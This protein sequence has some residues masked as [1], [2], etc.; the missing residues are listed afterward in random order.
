[1]KFI[2]FCSILL[3]Y[4]QP[5]CFS[6][7]WP[8]IYGIGNTDVFPLGGMF[9]TYDKGYI[10]IGQVEAGLYVPQIYGW[11]IK[12]DINGN[13]LWTK[14]IAS[15][16]YQVAFNGSDKT[17]DGGIV[18][19]GVTNKIDASNYDVLFVKLNA[20]GEKEWCD[21]FST[22]GNG[23]YGLKVRAI[24]GGYIALVKY[25]Q[26]WMYKRIWLFKLDLNGAV[27][28]QKLVSERDS[29]LIG[30][31][32]MDLLV[33]A[34]G[35]YLVT[36]DGYDGTPGHLYTLRPLILKTDSNG[37]N[38]WTL[39]F[40]HSSDFIGSMA[41]LPNENTIG[42]YY[43]AARHNLDSVP[44]SGVAPCFLKVSSAG[45]QMYYRDL[46]S[47]TVL[48]S[49]L[50]LNLKDNDTL[51]IYAEWTINN[52]DT[53]AILKCDTLG[54]IT[55]KKVLFNQYCGNIL[56]SLFTFDMKYLA[57]GSFIPGMAPSKLYLYKFNTNLEFDSVYT[58]PRT[59]D[60]LCPHPIVSDT[61][62]LDGCGVITDIGDPLSHPEKSRMVIYP[63]PAHDKITIRLPHYLKRES[64]IG[65]LSTTTFYHQ[66]GTI[67]L[68]IF[69]L[70]GERVYSSLI[71]KPTET[72]EIDLS[73]W[74]AGL[75]YARLTFGN[76]IVANEKFII[77]R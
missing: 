57:S 52:M 66:W 77:S 7:D 74:E 42:N 69:N 44:Y 31:E 45:Q 4:L 19:S 9:E 54:L 72:I 16:T 65:N 3:L 6:Q 67:S 29:I 59:Y 13:K 76:D 18:L 2:Y 22:P 35:D 34:N 70:N 32:G 38:L 53:V 58:M 41:L 49:A 39:S 25:F 64:S 8:K 14:T 17:N 26:D 30:Q 50:T 23:D 10:L 27:I 63:N 51:F 15:S 36:G 5:A 71:P 24:S 33:T 11:I 46:I 75:Y 62:S 47:G 73:D 20:C 56:S 28:W 1:M 68:E 48:G 55:K 61:M 43:M 40:G 60:S 21:I 37:N 12:T